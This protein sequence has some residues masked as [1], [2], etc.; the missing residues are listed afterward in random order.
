MRTGIVAMAR[1]EKPSNN[2]SVAAITPGA[3]PRE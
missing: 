2:E 3:F 1:A